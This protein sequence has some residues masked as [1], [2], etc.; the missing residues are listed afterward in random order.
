MKNWLIAALSVFL[1]SIVVLSWWSYQLVDHNL[2]LFPFSVYQEWQEIMWWRAENPLRLAREFFLIMVTIWGSYFAVIIAISRLEKPRGIRIIGAFWLIT[3]M[4]LFFGHNALSHDIFNYLFNAKMVMVYQA[5]PHIKTALDFAQDPW[6]RFMH[7]IHTPAPYA[8][9]WTALSLIPFG[10]SFGKFLLAYFG[11]KLWMF[12]ALALT[13]FFEWQLLKLEQWSWRERVFRFSLLAFHPLLLIETLM[14]GHNDVWMMWPVLAALWLVMVRKSRWWKRWLGAI[15]LFGLS[16]STKYASVLVAPVFALVAV[17]DMS[18]SF[19]TGK[20]K[21]FV[22]KW[23]AMVFPYWADFT[24]L[25]VILPLL[26]PR[27]Q[28]FHPW[29]AIWFLVFLPLCRLRW[30][31]ALLL[32][33]SLTSTFRYLPWLANGLEYNDLVQWNMRQITWSGLLLGGVFILALS[34]QSKRKK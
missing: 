25:L 1:A 14:N 7:N 6:V 18:A 9:G 31:Q 24:G 5:N 34:V 12:G 11:M 4:A 32:G 17:Q 16:L 21:K 3:A 26:T 30:V 20:G 2:T 10:L 19:L 15:A 27:S 33:L 28:Q 29:Y 8:W 22:Q 23:L 13:L